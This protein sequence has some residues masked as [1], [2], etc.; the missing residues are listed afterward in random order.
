MRDGEGESDRP[1][2]GGTDIRTE[3]SRPWNSRTLES[4]W[5]EETHKRP[6]TVLLGEL[7]DRI[8]ASASLLTPPREP[9]AY[10]RDLVAAFPPYLAHCE[11]IGRQ[12]PALS[13]AAF[14]KHYE[15]LE[16]WLDGKKPSAGSG[17]F[18]LAGP[19]PTNG[20]TRD[21]KRG[22]AEPSDWTGVKSG[23]VKF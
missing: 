16:E 12:I 5:T 23:E 19:P 18:R 20:K 7:A 3:K 15:F 13:V 9:E 14:E 6:A 8:A 22:R 17:E 11:S 4:V 21:P 2:K 1:P 10:G